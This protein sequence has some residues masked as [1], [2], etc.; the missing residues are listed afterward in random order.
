MGRRDEHRRS[1]GGDTRRIPQ[2]TAAERSHGTTIGSPGNDR[3][4][5]AS[6]VAVEA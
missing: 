2:Q 5:P 6:I 3:H 1:E 4:V